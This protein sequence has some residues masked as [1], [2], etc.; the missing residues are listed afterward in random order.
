MSRSAASSC[1]CADDRLARGEVEA[2]GRLV[3][4][5]E[6][7]IVEERTRDLDAAAVPAVQRTHRLR[8]PLDHAEPGQL[9]LDAPLR[10]RPRQAAEHGEIVQ[11]LPDGEVEVERR[12][13][14]DDAERGERL[15]A[16]LAGIATADDDPRPAAWRA[17]G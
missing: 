17:A 2:D 4:Q 1:T 12:L 10:L 16:G 13:L 3:E 11:V 14:E 9:A 8:R 6:L 5:E 15:G 7:R